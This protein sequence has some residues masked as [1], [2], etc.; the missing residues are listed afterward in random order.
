MGIM[1]RYHDVGIVTSFK[2]EI[3][4]SNLSV[5]YDFLSKVTVYKIDE[6]TFFKTH[7]YFGTCKNRNITVS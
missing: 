2:N 5:L 7:L 3:T 4:V 6:M 1:N